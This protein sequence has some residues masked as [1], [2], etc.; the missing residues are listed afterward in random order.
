MS[1]ENILKDAEGVRYSYENIMTQ[2]W[3]EGHAPGAE[4]IAGIINVRAQKCFSEGNDK[5]AFLLR[6]LAREILDL[7]VPTMKLKAEQNAKQH[8]EIV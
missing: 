2:G 1:K 6:S 4:F 8:P 5:D 3:L 7:H